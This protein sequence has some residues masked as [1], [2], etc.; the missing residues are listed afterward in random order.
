MKLQNINILSN[1][2][3]QKLKQNKFHKLNKKNKLT[4]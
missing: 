1:I 3:I 4:L 2:K